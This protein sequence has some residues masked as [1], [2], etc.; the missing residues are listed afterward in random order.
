HDVQM[1]AGYLCRLARCLARR[2]RHSSSLRDRQAAHRPLHRQTSP[3]IDLWRGSLARR[4][5]D[6]GVLLVAA[7][8]DGRGIYARLC[9]T[10][11]PWKY[12]GFQSR[13]IDAGGIERYVHVAVK[14]SP[15][16]AALAAL[17]VG[18]LLARLE[19]R[20]QRARGTTSA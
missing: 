1:A 19:V 18:W 16:A 20:K 7:R 17:L 11:R 15:Y 8:T 5:T 13:P 4:F 14:R 10:P 12:I 6:L 2:R 3:R 9:K